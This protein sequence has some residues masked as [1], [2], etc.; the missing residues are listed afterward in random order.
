MLQSKWWWLQGSGILSF[1]ISQ[2]SYVT[3]QGFN[4]PHSD[5][6]FPT[7]LAHVANVMITEYRMPNTEYGINGIITPTSDRASWLNTRESKREK[8]KHNDEGIT[9]T[10]ALFLGEWRWWC[11]TQSS[12][13]VGCQRRRR[14]WNKVRLQGRRQ[15]TIMHE[16]MKHSIGDITEQREGVPGWWNKPL[17]AN[18]S[19]DEMLIAWH[20]H[21]S[22]FLF[23]FPFP[24]PLL[25]VLIVLIL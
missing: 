19:R 23:L 20:A 2:P 5:L 14:G 18:E 12:T 10:Q 17:R 7:R 4:N 11:I 8:E 22:S 6:H 13:A 25:D 9:R 16:R 3:L 1:V 15:G 21:H 24:F